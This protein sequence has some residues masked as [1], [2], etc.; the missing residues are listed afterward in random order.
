MISPPS[1]SGNAN[2]FFL[3]ITFGALNFLVSLRRLVDIAGHQCLLEILIA[4]V[5]LR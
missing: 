2:F 4:L 3:V 1:L 5:E